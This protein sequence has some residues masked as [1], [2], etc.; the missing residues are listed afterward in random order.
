MAG[1]KE[2]GQAAAQ[3]NKK[4]YGPDFYREIGRKGG[5]LGTTGGFATE[6]ECFCSLIDAPHFKKNCAGKKGGMISRRTK[7]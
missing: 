1:T 4:K 3:T 5:K 6:I 2:G 7:A